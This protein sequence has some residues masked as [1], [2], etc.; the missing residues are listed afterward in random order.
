MDR[1]VMARKSAS[2]RGS[3]RRRRRQ[4]CFTQVGGSAGG[5]RG[6]VFSNAFRFVFPCFVLHPGFRA[7]AIPF[8]FFRSLPE[9]PS[10]SAR[11]KSKC[12][13]RSLATFRVSSNRV[14]TALRC[15]TLAPV[16]ARRRRGRID[17]C[18]G[19]AFQSVSAGWWGI[20]LRVRGWPRADIPK[21]MCI[22][23]EFAD[24]R[25]MTRCQLVAPVG[26]TPSQF[27]KSR[28]RS[29]SIGPARK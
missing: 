6:V 24:S 26:P 17:F 13:S 5:V 27:R 20:E 18:A 16:Y 8:G 2:P 19:V 3:V 11:R 21:A 12:A 1:R 22:R 10:F 9:A 29:A 14:P 23:L 28:L 25:H 4:G 7:L 15:E